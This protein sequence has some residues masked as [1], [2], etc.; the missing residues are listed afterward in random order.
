MLSQKRHFSIPN[1]N[2]IETPILLPSYSSKASRTDK[3]KDVLNTT[4]DIITDEILI[5]AY[6]AYYGHLP[7]Q[8][9]IIIQD[10][11]FLLIAGDMRH[12]QKLIYSI[13]GKLDR[14]GDLGRNL[15][16]IKCC[17]IGILTYLLY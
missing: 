5:S 11:L 16:I 4:K 1:H 7:P 2:T 13:L 14:K 8:K 9:N 15:F 10:D 12:L 3:V 6:D 17:R